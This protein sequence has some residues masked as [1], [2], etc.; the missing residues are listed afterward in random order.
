VLP[1][2]R[3][4]ESYQ[5]HSREVGKHLLCGEATLP[6]AVIRQGVPQK[7]EERRE[8]K[9]NT[10]FPAARIIGRNVIE[11]WMRF[12][13]REKTICQ[14][15]D[16]HSWRRPRLRKATGS[17]ERSLKLHRTLAHPSDKQDQVEARCNVHELFS[18]ALRGFARLAKCRASS[19]FQTAPLLSC[20]LSRG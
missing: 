12:L 8:E 14:V 11:N 20:W 10:S 19:H 6:K 9:P 18:S 15:I 7:F 5:D 17:R 1:F 4:R 16:A 13:R 3:S 2:S